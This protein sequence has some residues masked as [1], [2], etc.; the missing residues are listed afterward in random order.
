MGVCCG[1]LILAMHFTLGVGVTPQPNWREMQELYSVR[2][3]PV[4]S[5]QEKVTYLFESLEEVNRDVVFPCFE[6]ALSQA[7]RRLSGAKSDP[8]ARQ[9]MYVLCVVSAWRSSFSMFR[10]DKKKRERPV[11]PNQFPPAGTTIDVPLYKR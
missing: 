2:I 1:S 5:T 4:D 10:L 6:R 7:Q 3:P 11:Q 9:Q 8:Y